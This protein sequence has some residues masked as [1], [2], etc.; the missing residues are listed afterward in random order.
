MSWCAVD[1]RSPAE[2]RDRVAAWLVG[3]T[4]Q[5]IE[6]REDGTLIGYTPDREHAGSLLEA[7]HA[8][9][10]AGIEGAAR[11]LPDIDWS[12]RWRDGLGPRIIGRL[13]VTPSW[14]VADDAD[15]RT[16]IVDPESA[17]GTGE[18]GSTRTALVLLDRHLHE[19]DRVLDLGSGSG[20]LA[21]AAVKLGASRATGVEIDPDVEPIARG[22]AERNRV[23]ERVAFLTGDAGAIAPLLGPVELLVSNILRSVNVALLPATRGSLAS[24]GLAIFAGMEISERPLF[25]PDLVAAGFTP[26]DE[27]TDQSWWAVAAR[28]R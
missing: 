26:V 17:F 16:V 15:P 13:T 8:A 4:G 3:R 5:A 19:G 6:E 25:L 2:A 14:V 9:F 12:E 22:N 28:T 1:V 18:H 7:L 27:A 23:A 21:I 24:P 10:G 20:I 11:D